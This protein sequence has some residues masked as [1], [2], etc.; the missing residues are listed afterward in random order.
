[1]SADGLVYGGIC[2]IQGGKWIDVALHQHDFGVEDLVEVQLKS[3]GD[4]SILA[5]MDLG[6]TN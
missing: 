6:G 3:L 1:M 5:R 4:G 2:L